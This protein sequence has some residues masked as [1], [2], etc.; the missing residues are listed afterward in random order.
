M[1][2]PSI[3]LNADQTAFLDE[4]NARFTTTHFAGLG[5]FQDYKEIAMLIERR[6]GCR[7]IHRDEDGKTVL[8]LKRYYLYRSPTREAM[9]HQFFL[10]DKGPLHDH[11]ADSWGRILC[12]GYYERL[13]KSIVN[14]RTEGEYEVDRKPGDW[15]YRPGSVANHDNFDGYHKVKLRK[16]EDA[17]KVWTFFVMEKRNPYSWG[18][19]DNDGSYVPFQDMYKREGTD[20]VEVAADNYEYSWFPRRI[21]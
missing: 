8:Y 11:P 2:T 18:F 13:C 5:L 7:E 15:S 16:P 10:G 3:P 9:I 19:R 12:T 14:G 1:N 21:K 20:K 4:L 17:G 6:G